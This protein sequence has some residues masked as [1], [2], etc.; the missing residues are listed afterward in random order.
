MLL[1]NN[2]STG[3]WESLQLKVEQKDVGVGGSCATPGTIFD[4]TQNPKVMFFDQADEGVYWN[5]LAGG[6]TYC[7]G[8]AASNGQNTLGTFLRS[9]TD[10]EPTVYPKF[11]ATVDRST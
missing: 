2:T 1:T 4:G 6:S 7:I 5:G 9:A 11:T 8:L 10:S 3:G